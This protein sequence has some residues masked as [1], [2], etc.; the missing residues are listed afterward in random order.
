MKLSKI[1]FGAVAAAAVMGLVSCGGDDPN[2]MIKGSGKKYTI[3]YENNENAVSRGY[4][5]TAT[6]HAGALV[7]VTFEDI[8]QTADATSN[9]MGGV[10][11]CIFDLKDGENGKDFSVI[12]IQNKNNI[13]KYYISS[14]T[15][16]SD[17][18]ANNFGAPSDNYAGDGV[19]AETV[20]KDSTVISDSLKDTTDDNLAV[21]IYFVQTA[22][23]E[24]DYDYNVYILPKSVVDTVAKIKDADLG[25]LKDEEGNA[26]DIST[27][28]VGTCNTSYTSLTQKDFAVYANVYAYS[29]V[30]GTWNILD[31]Y[32]EAEVIE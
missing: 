15:G 22:T 31:T 7:K 26:I 23:A 14:Y 29:S 3:D 19:A 5:D 10:M 8:A 28:K 9:V 30:S 6:K 17:L 2:G 32:K 11:G 13:L 18:Q 12:G 1:L 27:Y 16:V 20:V 21:Y 25:V 24:D 4:K